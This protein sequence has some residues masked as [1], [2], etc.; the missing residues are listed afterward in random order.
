VAARLQVDPKRKFRKISRL[1]DTP[2]D[3]SVVPAMMRVS[4]KGIDSTSGDEQ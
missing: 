1:T 4:I 3:K 2:L